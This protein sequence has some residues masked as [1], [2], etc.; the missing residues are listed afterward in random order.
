MPPVPPTPVPGNLTVPP[1]FGWW[2]ILVLLVVVLVVA[3]VAFLF[4]GAGPAASERSEWQ[5][6][7]DGRSSRPEQEDRPT[8]VPA[9]HAL[10]EG[11]ADR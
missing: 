2:E 7:L 9:E 4:L 10:A 6:F 8:T 11:A 3:V 1:L 5:A